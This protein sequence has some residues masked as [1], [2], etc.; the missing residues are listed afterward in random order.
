MTSIFHRPS[1]WN[2][3]M[4]PNDFSKLLEKKFVDAIKKNAGH[5]ISIQG[6][7]M[8]SIF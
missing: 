4:K 6:K 5:T 8:T 3:L 2:I 7:C 1:L